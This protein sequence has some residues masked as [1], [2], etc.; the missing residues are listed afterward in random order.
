MTKALWAV[1]IF[2]ALVVTLTGLLKLIVSRE[3]LAP[4]MHWAATWPRERIKLLGLAEVAGAVGLIVPWA[5]GV[6]PVLT[7]I[8]A[9]C[10]AVLMGGAVQTHR[11]LG[12]SF[13]PALVI[14]VL[15]VAIAAGRL[16]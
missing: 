3:K 6:A 14:A 2:V 7:P 15:C 9:L 4:K 1:Q 8:A 10:L 11:K 12:E 13:V 16:V 5:T